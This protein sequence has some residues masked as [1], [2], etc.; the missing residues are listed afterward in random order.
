MPATSPQETLSR[1]ATSGRDADTAAAI[2]ARVHRLPA[3]AAY[4]LA[5]DFYR[6]TATPTAGVPA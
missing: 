5:L 3:A 4:N 1:L 2:L 6:R